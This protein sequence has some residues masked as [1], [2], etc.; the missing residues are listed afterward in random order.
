[1]KRRK[2]RNA[3]EPIIGHCKNDRKTGPKNWLKGTI[4]DKINT[5]A[6]AIGYNMRK[7]LRHL[8]LWLQILKAICSLKLTNPTPKPVL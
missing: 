2:R 5:I 3:I 4:G 1:M 6:M 7:I 8:F